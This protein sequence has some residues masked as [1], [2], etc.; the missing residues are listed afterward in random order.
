MNAIPTWIVAI[1]FASLLA[2]PLS[3]A[4]PEKERPSELRTTSVVE[5]GVTK[6]YADPESVVLTNGFWAKAGSD[7]IVRTALRFLQ[8]SDHPHVP[9]PPPDP[10]DRSPA[11]LP[12]CPDGKTHSPCISGTGA[13]TLSIERGSGTTVELPHPTA[14]PVEVDIGLDVRLPNPDHYYA[15]NRINLIEGHNNPCR[16][17]LWGNMIDPRFS[18]DQDQRLLARVELPACKGSLTNHIG[19]S[20]VGFNP[21]KHRFVRAIQVCLNHH[22]TLADVPPSPLVGRKGRLEVKGLA[23]R[24]GQVSSMNEHVA[25]L[26]DPI[27]TD[28]QPN[29]PNHGAYTGPGNG[30]RQ[31]WHVWS[32]WPEGQVAAGFTV[33]VAEGKAFSGMRVKCK[34]VRLLP[35]AVPAQDDQGY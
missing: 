33:Y 18:K 34:Y 11:R 5:A 3:Q 20:K 24:A 31:G 15:I 9:P 13:D 22:A 30:D 28:E 29:C 7:V 32:T 10:N 25:T 16:L 26:N 14:Y 35:G 4:A 6:E 21:A 19:M 1:T 17:Q 12:D 27:I 2:A 23:V 8:L